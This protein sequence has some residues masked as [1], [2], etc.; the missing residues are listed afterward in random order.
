MSEPPPDDEPH[1]IG[2]RIFGFSLSFL[3]SIVLT[4][5]ALPLL[6]GAVCMPINPGPNP[7]YFGLSWLRPDWVFGLYL[8]AGLG[9]CFALLKWTK[10]PGVRWGCGIAVLFIFIG[11]M[12]L[13]M[14]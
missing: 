3:L 6:L 9:G 4:A 8:V 11:L 2:T 1:K 7:G 10:N 12:A 5:I 13:G 14:R